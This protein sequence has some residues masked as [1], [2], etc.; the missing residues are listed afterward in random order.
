LCEAI[1]LQW[2]AGDPE[3]RESL[4]V[5]TV[6][7]IEGRGLRPGYQLEPGSGDIRVTYYT[8]PAKAGG[9]P[10]VPAGPPKIF[11]TTAVRPN[12]DDPNLTDV[13]MIV[14][15]PAKAVRDSA[16][17]QFPEVLRDDR[18]LARC[19]HKVVVIGDISGRD[20]FPI[21]GETVPG[22]YVHATAIEML[23][24]DSTAVARTPGTIGEYLIPAAG[25]LLGLILPLPLIRRRNWWPR[26]AVAA[27]SVLWVAAITAVLV[28]AV[29]AAKRYN[30]LF[31]P[32]IVIFAMVFAAVLTLVAA[33]IRR[34]HPLTREVP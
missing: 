4:S 12:D 34:S 26:W 27:V 22:M 15:L 18:A 19:D 28:A 32:L 6:T 23:L 5:A 21:L 1:L 16:T 8:D 10:R 9:R 11:D 29:I 3:P 33:A 13:T 31:N 25:A 2:A 20:S 14:P 30:Y 17:L 7:S 24:D